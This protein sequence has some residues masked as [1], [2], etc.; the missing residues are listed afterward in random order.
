M[1]MTAERRA[2]RLALLLSGALFLVA[3]QRESTAPPTTEPMAAPEAPVEAVAHQECTLTEGEILIE[4]V[5]LRGDGCSMLLPLDAAPG[6]ILVRTVAVSGQEAI[7]FWEQNGTRVQADQGEVTLEAMDL[8]GRV[9]GSVE[10]RAT[11]ESRSSALR[12][13]FDL[14]LSP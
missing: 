1:T 6:A 9:A 12:A 5:E 13:T 7:V 14:Q 8:D 3:C 2:I 11:V 10:A 4:Q